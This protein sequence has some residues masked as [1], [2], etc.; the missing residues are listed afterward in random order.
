MLHRGRHVSA[1]M[2]LRLLLVSATCCAFQLLCAP[3]RGLQPRAAAAAAREQLGRRHSDVSREKSASANRGRVPWNAGK[4]HSEATRRAIAAG[5][6]AAAARRRE[7]EEARRDKALELLRQH[8]P[9]R[10]A[11][12][13][14]AE[15]LSRERRA[16]RRLTAALQAE[17]LASSAARDAPPRPPAA[18]RPSQNPPRLVVAGFPFGRA[19]FSFSAESRAKISASL[20]KRWQDPEYRA[21][22]QRGASPSPE[23]RALLSEAMRRKW[24]DSDYRARVMVDR[25]QISEIRSHP[26]SRLT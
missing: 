15:I 23:T 24:Q 14:A 16:R 18:P 25:D 8:D 9:V 17:G 20:R 2:L 12:E 6:R 10:H 1:H 7:A 13:A 11:E 19:N 4:R 26:R 5:T 3:P 22:R 21:R